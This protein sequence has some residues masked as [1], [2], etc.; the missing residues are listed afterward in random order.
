MD[1]FEA[2]SADNLQLLIDF[3][4]LRVSVEPKKSSRRNS[5]TFRKLT[6]MTMRTS[7]KEQAQRPWLLQ[8]EWRGIRLRKEERRKRRAERRKKEEEKTIGTISRRKARNGAK[9]KKRRLSA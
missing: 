6:C 5:L 1:S 8:E 3:Q 4:D 9:R 2:A 7:F